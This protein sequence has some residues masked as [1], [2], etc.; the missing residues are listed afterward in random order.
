M[1]VRRS[2]LLAVLLLV[3]VVFYA[4]FTIVC[5]KTSGVTTWGSYHGEPTQVWAAWCEARGENR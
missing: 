4:G 1:V 2:N 3:V 5:L